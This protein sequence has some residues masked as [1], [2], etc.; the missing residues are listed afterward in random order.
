MFLRTQ[1]KINNKKTTIVIQEQPQTNAKNILFPHW[2][3]PNWLKET[4][5]APKTLRRRERNSAA[6]S[7]HS[8]LSNGWTR[9]KSSLARV[10]TKYWIYRTRWRSRL[11]VPLRFTEDSSVPGVFQY[12]WK[13]IAWKSFYCFLGKQIQE[14]AWKN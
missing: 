4:S 10:S 3:M 9:A 14:E 13:V 2:G 1:L 7:R 12:K 6:G 11:E 5:K 8:F